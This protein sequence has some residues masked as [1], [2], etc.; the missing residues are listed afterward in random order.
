MAYKIA[1]ISNYQAPTNGDYRGWYKALKNK[2]GVSSV[3]ILLSQGTTWHQPYASYQAYHAYK[4]FGNFSAYHFF[5]GSGKA[6]AQNFISALKSVGA[7]KSTVVMID[8][9][10][11]VNN[12]T[13]HINAFI[14]T[15]YDAGYTN[16]FV[17][18]MESMFNNASNGIQVKNLHHKPKIWVA[19]ISYAPRMKHDAWQYT[20]TGKV[21]DKSVDLDWDDTGLLAKGVQAAPK[22]A[23][24]K[25]GSEFEVLSAGV[26]VYADE[27]LKQPTENYYTK[28]SRFTVDKIVMDGGTPRLHNKYGY[29]SAN[30]KYVKK[31]K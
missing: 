29:L 23:F 1:D 26:R 20:W 2:Y 16:I 22:P 31:I 18:S 7:D 10:T 3:C 27:K 28:G 15:I 19:N 24:W 8:A 12:L 6:E 14:D 5:E 4:E 25:S 9:E 17:Y 13:G 11:K 30:K 21:W